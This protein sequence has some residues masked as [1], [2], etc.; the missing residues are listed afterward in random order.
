MTDC[1]A[2]AGNLLHRA[3]SYFHLN[4][5]FLPRYASDRVRKR[6]NNGTIKYDVVV[7]FIRQ[8]YLF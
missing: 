8:K 5:L 7:Q 4:F 6:E 2:V 1:N 3:F